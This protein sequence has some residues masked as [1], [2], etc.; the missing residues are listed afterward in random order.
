MKTDEYY[1]DFSINILY[2]PNY[3]QKVKLANFLIKHK[4][5][6]TRYKNTNLENN[7]FKITKKGQE[8]QAL[9]NN[10]VCGCFEK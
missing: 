3:G 6:K 1:N 8:L 7:Q 9:L 10:L 4:F 2:G 5:V